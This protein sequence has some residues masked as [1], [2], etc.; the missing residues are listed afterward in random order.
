MSKEVTII[1]PTKNRFKFLEKNISYYIQNQFKGN[2]LILDS[3][4]SS[5]SKKILKFIESCKKKI[6]ID[7]YHKKALPNQIIKFFIK[8]IKTKFSIIGADDDFYIPSTISDL[9]F[10]LKQKKK[11]KIV[12]GK[13][14]RLDFIDKRIHV[15]P[16]H[17]IN[18]SNKN[19]LFLE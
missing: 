7:Y 12:T 3:S 5:E 11:F 1:I 13:V 14:L 9:V 16:F 15:N 19:N 2:I 17:E 8:K 10:S 6:R 4:S 18:I